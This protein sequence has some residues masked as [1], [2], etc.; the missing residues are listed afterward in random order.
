MICMEL[1][2]EKTPITPDPLPLPIA[3]IEP[4]KPPAPGNPTPCT[5]HRDP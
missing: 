2:V 5:L 1:W 3:T 4:I